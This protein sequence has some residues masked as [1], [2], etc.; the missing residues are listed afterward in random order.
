MSFNALISQI[1][2]YLLQASFLLVPLYFNKN[3]LR[4]RTSQQASL[5]FFVILLLF[6]LSIEF[7][8]SKHSQ[9]S[10]YKIIQPL[11]HKAIL[12]FIFLLFFSFFISPNKW[13]SFQDVL[14]FLSYFAFYFIVIR[15]V[16]SRKRICTIIHT[17]FFAV[18]IVALYTLIQYYGWDP[19]IPEMPIVTSTIGQRNWISNYLFLSMPISFFFLLTEK[20]SKKK[21]F[22]FI[23]LALTY[24]DL[25]ILQSRGIWISIVVAIL[26]GLVLLSKFNISSLFF[27]NKKWVI[28]LLVTFV[29]ITAIY[30]TENFLNRSPLLL[31]DR[32]LPVLEGE[33]V[34][35]NA[36]LLICRTAI[37]MFKEH[38]ILGMGIGS[39]KINYLYEQAKVLER[40]PQYLPYY[41][42][43]QEAHN[44]Y[45]QLLAEIGIVG[46][47]IFLSIIY[48]FY[49]NILFFIFKENSSDQE[50]AIMFGFFIS[51]TGFLVHCF[52]AFPFHVPVLGMTFFGLMGLSEA[53]L[54]SPGKMDRNDF[55]RDAGNSQSIINKK[56]LFSNRYFIIVSVIILLLISLSLLNFLVF[57]PYYAELLYFRGLRYTVDK[58]YTIALEKFK[59]AYRLNPY[60]GKNL[61]TSGGT[62]YNLK[63]YDEAEHFLIKAKHYITDINT[64]YN[65]GLTY[66]VTNQIP[67]AYREFET[68]IKLN[69]NH[70]KSYYELG[71][72]DFISENYSGAIKKWEKILEIDSSFENSYIIEYNIGLTYK[73]MNQEKEALDHFLQAQQKAPE[74]SPVLRDIKKEI[75]NIYHQK[76]NDSKTD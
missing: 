22:Y 13:I 39:F 35:L 7:L 3:V 10:Y 55:K 53:Y 65:L 14:I 24:L 47:L 30:S 73:E 76:E 44:E 52:F 41:S 16:K 54:N 1:T 17:M 19:L 66:K 72:L 58:D 48:F 11:H 15:S 68:V 42:K 34:S 43:A 27:Q 46:L 74:G 37:E 18:F 20:E 70:L 32:V 40:N 75:S 60:D 64:F 33:D 23:L 69:P 71:L 45:L 36:R 59:T 26:F 62:C 56:N 21:L 8:F 4:F 29:F 61:H 38:L 6:F 28:L 63:R 5:Y 9:L 31:E 12:L 57:K 51:M 49:R 67:L 2:L 50:K 25:I